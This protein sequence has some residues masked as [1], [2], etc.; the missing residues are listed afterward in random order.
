MLSWLYSTQVITGLDASF[1]ALNIDFLSEVVGAK[2]QRWL[3][4]YWNGLKYWSV[5][6]SPGRCQSLLEGGCSVGVF[7]S[8]AVAGTA[9]CLATERQQCSQLSKDWPSIPLGSLLVAFAWFFK[10]RVLEVLL[11]YFSGAISAFQCIKMSPWVYSANTSLIITFLFCFLTK[12]LH[13]EEVCYS[14]QAANFHN[15]LEILSW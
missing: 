4:K 1:L 8:L 9:L 14:L 13:I 7:A 12:W 3:A 10:L 15:L 6:V 2:F 5:L 11:K